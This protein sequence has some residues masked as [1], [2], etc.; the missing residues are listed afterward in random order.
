MTR[1]LALT[2]AAL[3]LLAGV[4]CGGHAPARPATSLGPIDAMIAR[5]THDAAANAAI[6]ISRVDC[7]AVATARYQATSGSTVVR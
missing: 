7:L 3:G 6:G 1:R 5:C 4:G 2:L